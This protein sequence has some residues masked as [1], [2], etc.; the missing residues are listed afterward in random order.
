MG[1]SDLAGAVPRFG[2]ILYDDPTLSG[3]EI[4][5]WCAVAG[6]EAKRFSSPSDLDSDVIWVTDA[7]FDAARETRQADKH[8]LRGMSFLSTSLK[9]MM[10]DLRLSG[11]DI[12]RDF[13]VRALS[14]IVD[15]TCRNAAE[16]Y[17]AGKELFSG[18]S[19]TSGLQKKLFS[20]KVDYPADVLYAAK[21]AWQ[22]NSSCDL[23]VYNYIDKPH[24][25]RLRPNRVV[26]AARVLAGRVPCGPVEFI[27]GSQLRVLDPEYWL[28]KPILARVSVSH[29]APEVAP[30]LAFGSSF[31][32]GARQLREFVTTS[33]L[34]LLTQYAKVKV[35]AVFQWEG[36]EQLQPEQLL[37]EQV[38]DPMAAL[39]YSAGLI[40][41]A[42]L[43]AALSPTSVARQDVFSPRAAFLAARE[44]V[45]MFRLA[46]AIRDEGFQVTSYGAG[47]V[48]VRVKADQIPSLDQLVRDSGLSYPLP[49]EERDN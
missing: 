22:R 13:A 19:V 2:V 21:S 5:G 48:S 34:A 32:K 38:L 20:E 36:S 33:E 35:K 39:V 47:T 9:M 46:K 11:N 7:N 3:V 49:M 23:K 15:R 28:D 12:N 4:T 45:I 14:S 24:Y 44:R 10:D 42:H 27:P 37:P 18:F 26:H 16:C 40:A 43:G 30:I 31:G 8:N 17:G 29:V 1:P 25:Y 41:E 6:E